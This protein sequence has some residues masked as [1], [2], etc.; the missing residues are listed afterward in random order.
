V[1]SDFTWRDG[2]R[3]IRF[4]RGALADAPELLGD[5]YVLLT[6]PRAAAQAPAVTATAAAV[7]DVAPGRV[8]DVAGD[9]LETVDG[10]LFVALGG[11]RVIDVAKAL[12]AARQVQA[13][14]IPTTLSAAEMTRGHRHARGVDPSTPRVRPRIV[15]NDPAL[16][17]S[18]PEHDLA[19][20]AA[21]ALGHA[22]EGPLTPKASPVPVLAA[23][24]AARL[25]AH[26]HDPDALALGALLSGYVIDSA[27][28]GL[29]HVLAQTLARF[30]GVW[31]GRANAA[32]LPHTIVALRQRN[33]DALAA[34]DEAAGIAMEALARRLAQRADAQ[35]LRDLGVSEADLETCVRE[36]VGRRADL[37]GTP[38]AA[39]EAEIRALYEAAW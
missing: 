5:R 10:E 24:E 13:A 32:M 18:Q 3:T 26:D 23:R 29:H 14:A 28:Y 33:P 16:S 38:P 12:A 34:L 39:D 9:L 6:T 1:T 2:E 15:I 7:H 8:D 22:I 30:A 19:A 31:H 35:Q 25:L 20:S 4:G 17:A 37:A 21:N 36:A 11:G 27:G